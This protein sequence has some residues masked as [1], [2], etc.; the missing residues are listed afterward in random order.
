MF[1]SFHEI[2]FVLQISS[3]ISAELIQ[4]DPAEICIPLLL[5]KTM[6]FSVNVIN[7][8]DFYVAI[9]AHWIQRIAQQDITSYGNG[10]LPPRSTQKLTLGWVTDENEVLAN[11]G[12]FVWNR[13][14][15]EHVERGDI[16]SYMGED[17]SKKQPLILHKVSS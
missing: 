1:F 13:V 10:I 9:N 14:V 17:D 7:I 15:T 4:F 12:Y 2:V 6:L 8:T 11:E 5:N 3:S 16:I